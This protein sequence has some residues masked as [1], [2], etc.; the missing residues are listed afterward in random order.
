MTETLK[1]DNLIN[2]PSALEILNFL[3][4]S[5]SINLCDVESAM[6]N[7][8]IKEVLAHHPYS[9]YQDSRGRWYSYVRDETRK[10]NR[11]QIARKTKKDL[12]NALFEFYIGEKIL[13]QKHLNT[14]LKEFYPKWLKY[15]EKHTTAQTYISRIDSDWRKYYLNTEIVNI[16]MWKLTKIYLDEWAHDMIKKYNFTKKQYY[17]VT[18]IIRQALT[19]AVDLE[20]LESNPMLKVHVDGR[21][22]FRI[23]RKKS[24]YSQVYTVDEL[25]QLKALA[26]KDF[27]TRVKCCELAPL[28]VLFQFCTGMRTSEVCAIRYEDILDDNHIAVQRMYRRDLK[29]TVEHT[30]GSYVAREVILTSEA[31]NIIEK[32]RQRQKEKD[33]P[34]D[35]YIF[36]LNEKPL[37]YYSVIDLYRKYCK[38]MGIPLKSSHK[39]RKTYISTLIDADININTIREMVGHVDERTT[40]GNYCFDRKTEKERIAAIEAALG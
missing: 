13:P 7:N 22:M 40:L 36:S 4:D 20:I 6:R 39:A 33:A 1:Q 28:A 12:E 8:R 32:A 31:R 27:E 34:T 30:K 38:K 25:K 11:R 29:E 2:G 10:N 21:R 37:S 9:I 15:K 3:V 26:W 19:Y 5:G 24:N 35:G 17:N 23:E 16:P 18:L 14:T